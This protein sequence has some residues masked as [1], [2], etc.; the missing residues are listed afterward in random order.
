MVTFHAPSG[1]AIS[2]PDTVRDRS[3]EPGPLALN[4]SVL[5]IRTY[6]TGPRSFS[7]FAFREFIGL[8]AVDEQ[9]TRTCSSGR[10][11]QGTAVEGPA[12]AVAPPFGRSPL[13]RR[14]RASSNRPCSDGRALKSPFAVTVPFMNICLRSASCETLHV[15]CGVEC[16]LGVSRAAAVWTTLWSEGMGVCHKW[17]EGSKGPQMVRYTATHLTPAAP[18]PATFIAHSSMRWTA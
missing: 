17:S 16:A 9:Q 15:A 18:A 2:I 14:T 4:G 5:Q 11:G 13:S 12:P 8:V 6:S 10:R 7:S 3:P 1:T